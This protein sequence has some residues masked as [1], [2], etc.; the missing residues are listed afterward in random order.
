MELEVKVL[1]SRSVLFSNQIKL[2]N[3]TNSFV[4][5]DNTY[6]WN[7]MKKFLENY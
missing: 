3:L 4:D 5:L 7:K 6:E 1:I 2:K